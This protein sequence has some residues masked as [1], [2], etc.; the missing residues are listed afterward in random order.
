MDGIFDLNTQ[1]ATPIDNF[2]K[3]KELVKISSMDLG[4]F[5][6]VSDDVLI[7]KSK[8]DLW[9]M[10]KDADG[11]VFIS[12]LFEDDVLNDKYILRDH[13]ESKMLYLR[14]IRYLY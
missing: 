5:L 1:T 8:K 2:L 7:H 4:N 12:R 6:K 3:P 11:N 13:Y 10:Y 9:K 14:I